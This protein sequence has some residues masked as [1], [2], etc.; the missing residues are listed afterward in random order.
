MADIHCELDRTQELQELWDDPP[1]HLRTA[2]LH[3]HR[4]DVQS[5]I[6]RVL[7]ARKQWPQLEE[8]CRRTLMETV[9]LLK[10][11]S[12]DSS[13]ELSQLCG[14]RVATWSSLM[15]ATSEN[16]TPAGYVPF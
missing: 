2:M 6:M 9:S 10:V 15:E 12:P 7:L 16:N 5:V 1:E 4:E 14:R 3:N 8:H 11:E 13:S